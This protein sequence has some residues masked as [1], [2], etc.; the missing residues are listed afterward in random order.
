MTALLNAL[1]AELADSGYTAEETFGYSA[2]QLKLADVHLMGVWAGTRLVG[3]GGLELQAGHIGELK[4]FYVLPEHRGTGAADLLITHLLAY[5]T[6]HGVVLVRLETGD[7]QYAALRFYRRHGFVE[8][9][10]FGP[11]VGSATSVCLQ[12]EIRL[13][14]TALN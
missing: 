3:V 1:T 8:I 14:P 5:A 11:Y 10:R 2:E 9:P 4:R 6:R 13:A 7:K 12:R